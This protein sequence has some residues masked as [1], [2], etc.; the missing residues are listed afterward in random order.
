VDL[1][2]RLQL[3]AGPPALRRGPEKGGC[4]TWWVE[5]LAVE[6]EA[7]GRSRGGLTSKI[8]LA[9]DGRGLPMSVILTPGQAG[10]NPQLLPLLDQINVSR[11]GRGRPRK[12][13]E[14]VL[15]DKTSHAVKLSSC[16][17]GVGWYRGER[18]VFVVGLAGAQAV[19][20]AAEEAV[21]QVALRGGVSIAGGSAPV[22]VGAGAG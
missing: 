16:L 13:P 8:H 12:R 2:H 21:E 17:L 3:R 6:G 18:G 7:L 15:A 10:D 1:Q 22:V 20:Q 5:A 4:T 14:R 9:V 19:V 11:E